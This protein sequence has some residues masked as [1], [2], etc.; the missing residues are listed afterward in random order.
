LFEIIIFNE[1][2]AFKNISL[3]ALSFT[4]QRN[5]GFFEQPLGGEED[6][7]HVKDEKLR[8]CNASQAGFIPTSVLTNP[9][10]I[11]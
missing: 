2:S 8:Y 5:E 10:V 3:L 4:L 11:K 1:N 7:K 6:T 9:S